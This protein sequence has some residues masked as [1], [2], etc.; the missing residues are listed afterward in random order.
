MDW[1][2]MYTRLREV[3]EQGLGSVRPIAVGTF[4]GSL[5]S[6]MGIAHEQRRTLE[7][8]RTEV[9]IRRREPHQA[10]PVSA[11]SNYALLVIELDVRVV[12]HAQRATQLDDE[13]RDEF[14]GQ[15]LEDI[16]A[17]RQALIS[18]NLNATSA[19]SSTGIVS[20]RVVYISDE[21]VD[22]NFASEQLRSE[23]RMRFDAVVEIAQ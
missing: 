7:R 9:T 1:T 5:P 3:L 21:L 17:I 16:D 11:N 13:T 4:K 19:G 22:E 20:S 15:I 8:P 6:G 2:P 23:W 14:R 18:G 12:Y 10:S